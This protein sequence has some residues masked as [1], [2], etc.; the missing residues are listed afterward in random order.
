MIKTPARVPELRVDDLELPDVTARR[1][2]GD[3]PLVVREG[4]PSY[5]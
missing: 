4:D 1:V 2:V 5:R 3:E